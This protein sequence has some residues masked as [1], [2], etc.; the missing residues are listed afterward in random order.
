ML[1]IFNKFFD[2]SGKYKKHFY[3]SIILSVFYS[4]FE[5]IRIP[6]IAIVLK[7]MLENNMTE[8][9]MFLSLGIMIVSIVGCSI[10]KN[11]ITMKQTIGGYELCANKRIDI[12][13]HLKYVPMGYLND[14]S[15]G[16]ITSITTNT[17][18][19]LQDVATRVI[20]LSTQGFINTCIIGICVL[21]YDY[22]IGILIFLGILFFL[23]VNNIMQKKSNKLS[24][25]KT[26]SDSRLV[27]KILEY[28]QG[29]SIVKSYN[30]SHQSNQKVIKAI[31][32]NNDINYKMEKTFIPI[33]GLQT[34]VL[35]SMGILV[36]LASI[37]FYLNNSMTLIN[38]VLMII[39][40]FI[41]YGQLESAGNYSALLRVMDNCVDKVNTVFDTPVM[42]VEGS[43]IIPKNYD[44]NFDNVSFSYDNRKVI[45]NMLFDIPQ[46]T[47][48]AIVGPSGGGKT[49][50]CNLIA[51]F[52][53]VD[54]GKITL[55]G[56][57]IRRYKLDSLLKN[58]SMVFQDV[59]LFQDTVANNIKF[60][61]NNASRE[62]VIKAA[63][64]ASCHDFIINLPNGYDT[65]I[66]EG[67]TSLSGG[68]KQRISIARAML[69]DAPIIILDEATA[70]VDAENEKQLQDAIEELTR[71]K[72]IIMIAHR[73]KT[74]RNADQILVVDDGEIVQR[75]DHHSLIKEEGI[76]KQFIDVRKEAVGWQ[77]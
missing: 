72:T 17:L 77:L 29:I 51:R 74:V 62:D 1:K 54:K 52:F 36:I 70:N 49:T 37:Y 15:L 25:I 53:D 48:T 43:E 40:S 64:K 5:A 13:Q 21:I 75:G 39:C 12:A 27:D 24:P 23:G 76:Y 35:K 20:M 66:G 9:T 18:E 26:E 55:G 34:F 56:N 33:M 14:N 10:L 69:K 65:V 45:D 58:I 30:L 8:K 11:K 60:G 63:K 44:I 73:L 42:D 57:D 16:Y 2:F 32:D 4:I 22:R 47:T 50:I 41:I 6:A 38:C 71:D 28:I 59:Y 61:S 3:D 67:G 68:E 19:M 31:D 46:N 7:D